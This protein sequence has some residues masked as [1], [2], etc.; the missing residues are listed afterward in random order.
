LTSFF[1]FPFIQSWNFGSLPP[2]L[3]FSASIFSAVRGEELDGFVAVV[4]RD[5]PKRGRHRLARAAP[6]LV[7]VD[8]L[9]HPGHLDD[10]IVPI[11]IAA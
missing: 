1:I 4:H 8:D 10:L 9:Q 2:T 7:D 6:R 3:F 11:T 5:A